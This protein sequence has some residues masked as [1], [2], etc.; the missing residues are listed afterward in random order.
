MEQE[1]HFPS[2]LLLIGLGALASHL[3][4]QGVHQLSDLAYFNNIV[5]EEG[6]GWFRKEYPEKEYPE[7]TDEAIESC[8]KAMRTYF[9]SKKYKRICHLKLMSSI[10]ERDEEAKNLAELKAGLNQELTAKYRLAIARLVDNRKQELREVKQKIAELTEQLEL[11]KEL[12]STTKLLV[13][14]ADKLKIRYLMYTRDQCF[15]VEGYSPRWGFLTRGKREWGKIGLRYRFIDGDEHYRSESPNHPDGK[16]FVDSN[17]TQYYFDS[18][19]E[20]CVRKLDTTKHQAQQEW[21]NSY[22]RRVFRS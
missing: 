20:L 22:K 7:V 5:N 16:S 19:K 2:F 4:D 9:E 11:T 17:G 6:W 1:P 21:W 15:T 14:S 10:Q 3:I 13:T 8:E 18:R 12:E